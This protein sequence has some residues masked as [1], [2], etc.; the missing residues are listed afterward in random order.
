MDDDQPQTHPP[1]D[2]LDQALVPRFG[3]SAAALVAIFVGAAIGTVSRYLLDADHPVAQGHFPWVTLLINLTGSFAI[4]LVVP[5][6]EHMATRAP[7]ARPFLV[8]GILGGWTTYS[9][10][11]V[12]STLLAKDGDIVSFVVYLTATVVVGGM[13]VV[14][15]NALGRRLV[16]A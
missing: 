6:T 5:L 16:P 11:A 7:L 3:F 9:T 10:L 13:L 14:A 8:V 15:G 4:G 12:E 2:A 1:G